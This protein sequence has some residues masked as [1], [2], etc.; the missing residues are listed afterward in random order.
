MYIQQ[1]LIEESSE[2]ETQLI[3]LI[4][5][6]DYALLLHTH[7]T[8]DTSQTI[9]TILV[10]TSNELTISLKFVCFNIRIIKRNYQFE[11]EIQRVF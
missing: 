9:K 3:L 2:Q 7:V 8:I 10:N 5:K 4:K 1:N 6:T 11:N